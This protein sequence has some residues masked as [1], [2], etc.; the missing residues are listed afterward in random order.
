MKN[1]II[2]V[3]TCLFVFTSCSVTNT[4]SS[5]NTDYKVKQIEENKFLYI[6]DVTRNDSIFRIISP[7]EIVDENFEKIKVGNKYPLN[8][9]RL[10]PNEFVQRRGSEAATARRHVDEARSDWKYIYFK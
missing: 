6:I 5:S 9:L 8:L 4:K 1:F 2:T 10:Y 7:K 3:L